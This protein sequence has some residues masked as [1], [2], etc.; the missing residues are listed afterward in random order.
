MPWRHRNGVIRG[1]LVITTLKV[2]GRLLGIF[3][4]HMGTHIETDKY[5][6][7]ISGKG[8][9]EGIEAAFGSE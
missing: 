7:F 4:R 5:N 1:D 3:G 6:A 2:E 9:C 8:L